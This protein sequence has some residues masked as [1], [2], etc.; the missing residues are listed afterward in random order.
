MGLL[1]LVATVAAVAAVASPAATEVRV[2]PCGAVSLQ[3]AELMVRWSDDEDRAV[4]SRQPLAARVRLP[5]RV[6]L[7][8]TVGCAGTGLWCPR[9]TLQEASESL[10]LPVHPAAPLRGEVVVDRGETPPERL[11]VQARGE[12]CG[13]PLELAVRVPVAEG[14]FEVSLPRGDL[15]LRFAADGWMPVYRWGLDLPV[16]GTKLESIGLERGG[17][18]AGFVLDDAGMP[19]AG[20]QVRLRP[21]GAPTSPSDEDG[22]LNR[23]A[24]TG[25]LG[26]FQL[27]G[28]E[29][30][31]YTLEATDGEASALL[32]GV[33]VAADSETFFHDEL[34][35]HR[36]ARLALTVTPATAGGGEPWQVELRPLDG[37]S[38]D[39]RT[40]TTD[41]SG[42]LL[43]ED[44][45]A[46]RYRLRLTSPNGSLV[47]TAERFISGDDR[48]VF[49]L[50]LVPLEGRV[51]L[52]DEPVAGT[53]T[54][55]TGRG[56]AW[57]FES[58]EE[59]RFH[60]LVERPGESH[61][62]FATVTLH[63]PPVRRRLIVDRYHEDEDGLA[64]TLRLSE[65]RLTG[66][67][68]AVTGEPVPGAVVSVEGLDRA[69]GADDRTDAGGRFEIDAVPPGRFAVRA[70]AAGRGG[71]APVEITVEK[72]LPA[73]A[74]LRFGPREE[75]RGRLL[76]AAGAPL[77]G[78]RVVVVPAS[79]PG[80]TVSTYTGSDGTF[81][82]TLPR[83]THRA[84]VQVY[85]P[86]ALAWS[87][88]VDLPDSATEAWRLTLPE[89]P[90]GELELE[91]TADP[92][93]PLLVGGRTLILTG[94]GGFLELG[95]LQKMVARLG[96]TALVDLEPEGVRAVYRAAPLAADRYTAAW[97]RDPEELWAT[98][99]CS[100]SDA[101]KPWTFLP[102]GGFARLAL[103]H[104]PAQRAARRQDASEGL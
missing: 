31:L 77:A 52:G 61:R 27:A 72:E 86:S 88:C 85:A 26:F 56:D 29:E 95:R 20:A 7:D 67:V 66:H 46:G 101:P 65:L 83:R 39:R 70:E 64:V 91:V 68:L 60:G 48:V 34:T 100:W 58:D 5:A 14:R 45:P 32:D 35:L 69:F 16:D 71:T 62:L 81:A 76:T 19:V 59:G 49:E 37:R 23:A 38:A 89:P 43:V 87:G 15:D 55:S 17:S 4:E 90:G 102:A 2:E 18:V 1:V 93:L 73:S 57:S 9:L 24:V 30:G 28:I 84:V 75:R 50:P 80:A 44:L 6:P 103:D 82:V 63:D 41:A 96:T 40:E 42:H 36:P 3:E 97:T 94:D 25:P 92:D 98:R 11:L 33:R 74:L 8:A 12:R 21:A 78:A 51:F 79:P 22:W 53:V 13:E 54:L 99:T 104:E 10:A 47:R